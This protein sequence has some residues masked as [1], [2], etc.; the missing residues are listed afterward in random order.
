[1]ASILCGLSGETFFGKSES[2][3][4]RLTTTFEA[5]Q[6]KQEFPSCRNRACVTR[7][8]SSRAGGVNVRAFFGSI[9]AGNRWPRAP[10]QLH[11]PE[12]VEGEIAHSAS[13]TTAGYRAS[14]IA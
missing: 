4:R 13:H 10:R 9:R 1:M 7:A 5:C 3:T 2:S 8:S 12:L 11:T 6:R 14:M